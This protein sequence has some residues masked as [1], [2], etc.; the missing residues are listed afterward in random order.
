MENTFDEISYR[1]SFATA[2]GE[3]LEIVLP[4]DEFEPSFRGRLLP[5]QPKIDPTFIRQIGFMITDKQQGDFRLE[6]K[7]IGLYLKG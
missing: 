4:F 5:D 7:R 3:W 1:H 2:K 6:V